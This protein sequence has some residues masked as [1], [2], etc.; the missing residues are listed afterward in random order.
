MLLRY[1]LRIKEEI[2]GEGKQDNIVKG[3]GREVLQIVWSPALPLISHVI[4][5]AEPNFPKQLNN[6]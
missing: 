3:T 1:I 4:N 2:Q 5:N 6:P